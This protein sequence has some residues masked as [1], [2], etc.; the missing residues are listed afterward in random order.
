MLQADSLPAEP[1]R[2]SL[3][4]QRHTHFFCPSFLPLGRTSCHLAWL[5][6]AV[7]TPK[8]S[9][10]CDGWLRTSQ[11]VLHPLGYITHLVPGKYMTWA[12]QS[13]LSQELCEALSSFLWD[14][15]ITFVWSSLG[16]HGES[17]RATWDRR[18]QRGERRR[19]KRHALM[20]QFGF[21]SKST[22]SSVHL[23][24]SFTRAV[25]SLFSLSK[26]E[27]SFCHNQRTTERDRQV[28]TLWKLDKW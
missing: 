5:C 28:Y 12:G 7:L 14:L 1:Q 2:K 26:S 3:V 23:G 24:L 13:E 11:T 8:L 4:C 25:S 17:W 6:G 27:L 21:Q 19:K 15:R 9:S 18:Q 10:R 16:H 22:R 20:I